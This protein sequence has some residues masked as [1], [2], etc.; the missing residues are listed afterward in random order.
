MFQ[1]HFVSR[2]VHLYTYSIQCF[3]SL[4]FI[5]TMAMMTENIYFCGCPAYRTRLFTPQI[6]NRRGHFN[7]FLALSLLNALCQVRS[8]CHSVRSAG[9]R[10]PLLVSRRWHTLMATLWKREM[11]RRKPQVHPILPGSIVPYDV[12][13]GLKLC[14]FPSAG[15]KNRFFCFTWTLFELLPSSPRTLRPVRAA[16]LSIRY[17]EFIGYFLFF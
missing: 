13:S 6:P 2:M 12:R 5:Q 11:K 8:E 17:V 3:M 16:V 4:Q 14:L 10:R 9:Q 15:E 7:A 1:S